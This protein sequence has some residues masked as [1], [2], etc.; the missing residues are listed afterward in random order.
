MLATLNAYLVRF[1]APFTP[2]EVN[3][4]LS[5]FCFTSRKQRSTELISASR[6]LFIREKGDNGRRREKRVFGGGGGAIAGSSEGEEALQGGV[7]RVQAGRD[8]QEQDRHPL[9]QLLLRVGRLSLR[10]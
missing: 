2:A 7:P 1:T 5:F 6:F 4:R 10:R 3:G 8:Q 9:P